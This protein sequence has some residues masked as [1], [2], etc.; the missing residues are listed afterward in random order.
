MALH[1]VIKTLQQ[2]EQQ[3]VSQLSKIRAAIS[4]L[5]SNI[6]FVMTGRGGPKKRKLGRP[7]KRKRG[8]LS[9]KGRAAIAAAQKARWAKIRAAKK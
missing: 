6:G 2:E 8:K 5:G 4:A 7:R 1:D 3:L 9:A